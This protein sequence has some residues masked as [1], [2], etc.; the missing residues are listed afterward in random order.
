[1]GMGSPIRIKEQQ[2]QDPERAGTRTLGGSF[3][4]L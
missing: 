2:K 4:F 3:D 1:M